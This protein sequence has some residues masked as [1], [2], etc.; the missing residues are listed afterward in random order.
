MSAT[1]ITLAGAGERFPGRAGALLR[2]AL[3][4]IGA[5]LIAT[6]ALIL[7]LASLAPGGIRAGAQGPAAGATAAGPAARAAAV[8]PGA[9]A[10]GLFFRAE[11]DDMVLEAP[12]LMTDVRIAVTGL[13]SRVTVRQHFVNPSNA[14]MEG[15][16]VFP[17]PERSA[18]D[19]LT[20]TVGGREIAGRIMAREAARKT[21]E[22]AAAQGQRASLLSSERANVFT[23]AVANI[24]PGEEIVIEI[25]YQDRVAYD[26]GRFSLRFPMVVAPRYTPPG[27]APLAEAPSPGLRH[28][29]TAGAQTLGGEGR[30]IFGPVRH[31]DKGPINPLTLAVTLDAGLPLAE[32]ESLYHPVEVARLDARRRKITLA[33]GSVPADRDFVLEWRPV[34]GAAPEAAV[35]GEEVDGETYLT[36]MVVP[37]QAVAEDQVSIPRDLIF[38][39][40]TSGSM[41]GPS[42]EQ[43]AEAMR[44]A[45]ERLRPGDRFNVIRFASQTHSLFS[46]VKPANERNLHAARVYLRS[47]RAEGGTNM[48]PALFRALTGSPGPDR[49]RQVVFLTDG[50]VSNEAQL[51][52]VIA[53]LLGDTRLFTIGI[54]SAP[55]SYFMRKAAELGRGSFTYIGDVSEVGRRMGKL[56][57][58]L[59]RPALVGVQTAWPAVAGNSVEAYPTPVPDLYAGEPVTFS[60]KLPAVPLARLSGELVVTG[61]RGAETWERRLSL[62]LVEPAP[63]VAAIW[64][65]AKIDWI[66]DGLY[67]REDP[68]EVRKDAVAV[69]L[70]HR[71]VT[72][73]TSLVAVDD[74]PARPPEKPL[75]SR[76][77]ERNLPHGMDY[78]QVFGADRPEMKMRTLT[79]GLMRKIKAVGQPGGQ[80]VGLPQTATPAELQ[81]LVGLGLVSLGLVLLLWVRRGRRA[82]A[83]GA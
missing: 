32:L 62:S 47:L 23:T 56:L 55:N 75:E 77:I 12:T 40:D 33:E 52:E 6:I 45:L 65:R 39:I 18:V 54:G 72:R 50:A 1:E 69:A 80:P 64:A 41:Y 43:A 63:G 59:A 26:D 81:A 70:H 20:M 31:P 30:D 67:R 21:Y 49:L 58:K 76:A 10:A 27:A 66:E 78:T 61:R 36:V 4:V 15:I 14:W 60:A 34:V 25:E 24:G 19:R 16:Y 71:L 17:L 53:E 2:G 8:G 37:P 73:Y 68:A 11:R 46:D 82:G 48:L 7:L 9:P 79:P 13:I 57:E 42:I 29:S 5:I 22:K 38:V 83:A 44:L 3:R 28:A 35:F 74:R 51:F